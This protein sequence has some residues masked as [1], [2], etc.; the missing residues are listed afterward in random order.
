MKNRNVLFTF[1]IWVLLLMLAFSSWYAEG[2]ANGQTPKDKSVSTADDARCERVSQEK[3]LSAV[4][5]SNTYAQMVGEAGVKIDTL[6]DKIIMLQF[7]LDKCQGKNLTSDK[8]HDI[9]RAEMEKEKSEISRMVIKK[10]NRDTKDQEDVPQ[11][12]LPL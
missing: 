4:A 6:Q 5:A 11:D 2:P 7:L 1:V 3:Y 8:P 10:M 9:S 12:E